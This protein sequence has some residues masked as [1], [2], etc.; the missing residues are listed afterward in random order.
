MLRAPA[1]GQGEDV[2]AE[3]RLVEGRL[4]VRI[5]RKER[6]PDPFSGRSQEVGRV[7][8]AGSK[9]RKDCPLRVRENRFPAAVGEAVRREQQLRAML[10]GNPPR[11]IDIAHG[12]EGEPRGLNPLPGRKRP[13]NE[14][15]YRLAVE[16]RL[17]VSVVPALMSRNVQPNSPP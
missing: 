10:Q 4:R 15:R 9:N 8:A 14:P 12:E 17:G 7:A 5:A 16:Q 13:L 2:V 11:A 6:A 1:G 3:E